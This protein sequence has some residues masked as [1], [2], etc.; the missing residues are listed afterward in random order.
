[1]HHFESSFRD[2][3]D[4]IYMYRIVWLE[5]VVIDLRGAKWPIWKARQDFATCSI[6]LRGAKLANLKSPPRLRYSN[7]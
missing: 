5:V 6:G 4:F 3:V 1:M 2:P 7:H